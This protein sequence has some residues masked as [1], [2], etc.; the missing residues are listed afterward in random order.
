MESDQ[1]CSSA[2]VRILRWMLW[3]IMFLVWAWSCG[4]YRYLVGVPGFV[5]LPIMIIVPVCVIRSLKWRK[6]ILVIAG[7]LFVVV[8]VRLLLERPTWDRDWIDSC[9]KPPVVRLLKDKEIVEIENVREFKWRSVDDYDEAWVKHSYYL[10]QLDSLDLVIE[11]LGDSKLFAHTMLS[12]GFGPEMRVVISAEVRKEKGEAFSIFSGLYKQFELIYQINS[13]RDALTLRGLEEG[14]Q[15]YLFPIKASHDFMKSLFV[16][17][18]EKAGN[19]TDEP[20]FYHS[21]RANC[22]TELFDHIKKNYDGS[23]NYGKGVLFPAQSGKVLHDMGWMDTDLDY[24]KAMDRFRSGM[25][26][27][28]FADD[29]DFSK[30]IRE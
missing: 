23:I 27:R 6:T 3:V 21:L 1:L 14:T 2:R 11:P 4:A 9:R 13:E 19:L 12:F 18:T 26:V 5:I 8:L 15:L 10:D 22:T 29:P 24:E 20:K 17:M 16:S 30:K 25:R 28:K 7:I